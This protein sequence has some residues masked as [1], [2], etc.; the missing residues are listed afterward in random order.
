MARVQP[1]A[2]RSPALDC[3]P[4]S[5]GGVSVDR[6]RDDLR[7]IS[8]D[9]AAQYPDTNRGSIANP[10]APRRITAIRYSQLDPATGA[11]IFLIGVIVGGA[12]ALLLASAC[13][14][15]GSLLLS[16]AVSRRHELAVKMALGATR[17]R[18]VRQLLTE[19]LCLSL[20][21]GALGLLFAA[22]TAGAIPALFMAEQA[23]LL[24]TRPDAQLILLTV[25]V[26]VRRAHC[27][28]S[29][30]LSTGRRRARSPRC[31][32]TPAASRR[33]PAAR[34]CARLLVGAQIGALDRSAARHRAARRAA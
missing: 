32:L 25:G 3:R 4:A 31:G 2:W 22:W 8:D 1:R 33:S 27:S 16:R 15:V 23:A 19:T 29:R 13:L 17:G 10:D 12:S 7:R 28:A 6:R 21:G 26:A 18:L 5:A 9:L 30:R 14:N 34:V 20:A 11:Q 24:D